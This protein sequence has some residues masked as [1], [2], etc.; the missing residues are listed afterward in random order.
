M[1]WVSPF[2]LNSKHSIDNDNNNSDI[3]ND[4]I[5]GWRKNLFKDIIS[6]IRSWLEKSLLFDEENASD[7]IEL[8]FNSHVKRK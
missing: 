7:K 2:H 6:F 4:D 8:F 5:I 1:C 3:N